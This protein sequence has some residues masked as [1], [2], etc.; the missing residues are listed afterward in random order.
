MMSGQNSQPNRGCDHA[1][2]RLMDYFDG[3][4]RDHASLGD[5]DN[6]VALCADCQENLSA[7][8]EIRQK[9][10]ALPRPAAPDR[11]KARVMA[12]T[13]SAPASA[14]V[15]QAP[16]PSMT[17]PGPRVAPARRPIKRRLD[18]RKLLMRGLAAVAVLIILGV[19][20]MGARWAIV[21]HLE[22]QS[23]QRYSAMQTMFMANVDYYISTHYFYDLGDVKARDP[24]TIE[25][26]YGQKEPHERLGF[27]PILPRWQSGQVERAYVCLIRNQPAAI[28]WYDWSGVKVALHVQKRNDLLTPYLVDLRKDVY[29]QAV[30]TEGL[31]MAA[32]R[33]ADLDYVIVV[34]EAQAPYVF[35]Q[36]F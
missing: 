25:K 26:W 36:V 2:G 18:T 30:T 16:L 13:Q 29:K 22:N 5:L 28:V 3:E 15:E 8:R 23:R 34:P 4:A 6:Q 27:Q 10:Q 7:L 20:A 24:L 32:W 19:T 35:K 14:A 1:K 21:Q 11:L 12:G 9:V 17:L 31:T 33:A